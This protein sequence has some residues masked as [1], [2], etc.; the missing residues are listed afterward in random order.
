MPDGLRDL[1][2]QLDTALKAGGFRTEKRG[3]KAHISLVRRAENGQVLP[4]LQPVEWRAGEFVLVR[5]TLSSAG[6]AYATLARFPLA[7]S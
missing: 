2:A 7:E 6:P 4:A 3:F 1:A 5:S